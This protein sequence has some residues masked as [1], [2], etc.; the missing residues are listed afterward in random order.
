MCVVRARVALARA[1]VCMQGMTHAHVKMKCNEKNGTF[2]VYCSY[3]FL[4]VFMS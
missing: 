2:D 4:A 3:A 1:R